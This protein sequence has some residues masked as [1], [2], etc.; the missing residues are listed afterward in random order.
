MQYSDKPAKELKLAKDLLDQMKL[1]NDLQ[2]LE[3]FWKRFLHHLDRVWNK[4]ENHY[5]KSPKWD[6]WRGKFISQRRQDPLLSYLIN[7]RNVDEHSISEISQVQH[8]SLRINPINKGGS[9]KIDRLEFSINGKGFDIKSTSPLDIVFQ[10]AMVR[11]LPVENRGK[12]YNPPTAHLGHPID[13]N[14]LLGAARAGIE[15]YENFLSK[16]DAYFVSSSTST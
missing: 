6:N 16:S 9:L 8:G 7:A 13:P 11:L 12:I 4:A 10:P 2:Q 5:R 14:D 1:A 15:F 3:E